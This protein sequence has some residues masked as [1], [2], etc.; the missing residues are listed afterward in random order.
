VNAA[1]P[2]AP[3]TTTPTVPACS[4]GRDNDGDGK[5]DY[6][7]DTGCTGLRDTN[8]TDPATAPIAGITSN[9]GT[10]QPGGSA[11]LTWASR[12]TAGCTGTGFSTG[13]A[14]NGSVTVSP[15]R[16]T[17]YTLS[18]VGTDGT[19]ITR[20]TR[21]VVG[22]TPPTPPTPPAPTIPAPTLSSAALSGSQVYLFWVLSGAVSP[23]YTI[24]RCAGAACTNFTRVGTDTA[25]PYLDSGLTKGT[26]YRYRVRTTG[27]GVSNVVTAVTPNY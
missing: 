3:A 7:E 23:T 25:S 27:G 10:I 17:R 21:V 4:D 18:C 16:T 6:P 9:P 19:T 14:T 12:R 24:E 15:T 2:T 8:E 20:T 1:A 11:T 5:R 13:G 22:T 26:T